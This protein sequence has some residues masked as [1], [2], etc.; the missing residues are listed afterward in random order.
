VFVTARRALAGLA[1]AALVAGL[2]GCSGGGKPTTLPSLT[3]NTSL[4]PTPS[5]SG[6]SAELAA[7][8]AVVRQWFQLLQSDTTTETAAAIDAITAPNCKCRNASRS[9]RAAVA[10]HQRYVGTSHITGIVPNLDGTTVAEVLVDYDYS[11]GGLRDEAGA[12]VSRIRARKNVEANFRLEWHASNW[13]IWQI[14]T[15][16]DGTPA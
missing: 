7:V 5:A 15:V 14:E 3:A 8:T 9:I 2:A 13:R 12:W 10:K 1:A 16:R 11:A 4:S 6:K